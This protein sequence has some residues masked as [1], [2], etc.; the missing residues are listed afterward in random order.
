[1][2]QVAVDYDGTLVTDGVFLP[3][4]LWALKRLRRWKLQPVITSARANWDGGRDEIQQMLARNGFADLEIV[5][6][7][8]A[9]LYIDDRGHR[10]TD[11]RSAIEATAQAHDELKRG[12]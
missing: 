10:F 5:A 6:K 11:W 4:A 3:N 2:P 9:I 8:E 7:P 1:M 12:R